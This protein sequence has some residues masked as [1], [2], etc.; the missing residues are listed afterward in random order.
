MARMARDASPPHHNPMDTFTIIKDEENGRRFLGAVREATDKNTHALGFLPYGVYDEALSA[1]RLWVVVDDDEYLG[2]LLFGGARPQLKVK[3]LYVA[4]TSRRRGIARRLIDELVALGEAEGYT[5]IR[6][7]VADDLDANLA[8]ERLG[9]KTGSVVRGGNTTG[10]QIVVR[11]RRLLPRGP[12]THFLAMLDEGC[13]TFALIARGMPLNR[14]HWYTIDL[15]VWL[16]FACR[17]EPFYESA[18]ALI[19]GASRG[20]YRL[21]FTPEAIEEARRSARGRQDDPLHAIAAAWQAVPDDGGA[22]VDVLVEKLRELIFPERSLAGRRAAN[23]TSDL[24]HLALSIRAGASGFLTREQ[25]LLRHRESLWA[26]YGLDV[27]APIDLIEG[28]EISEAARS[29]QIMDVK[30][31]AITTRW[32]DATEAV[33]RHIS[34]G[35]RLRALDREDDGWVIS[36]SAG[37]AGVVYWRRPHR[38]DVE[39]F[40]AV[41]SDLVL[42]AHLHQRIFDIL[43]GQVVAN[44][45]SASVLFRLLLHVDADS[46]ERYRADLR[47]LGF[48]DTLDSD[49]FIRFRSG[50]P[51]SVSTWATV[52]SIV[53]QEI[54]VQSHW[55]GDR[56]EGPV[57]RFTR[58][59][60]VRELSRFDFETFFGITA[61]TL[62]ARRAHFVPISPRHAS[63]L[64][65]WTPDPELFQEHDASFRIERVYFR[66]PRNFGGVRSGDLV[67]FYET[68]PIQAVVGLARCTASLVLN[69]KEAAERF[70]RLAVLDPMALGPEVHC[71]AFDNYIRLNPVAR[72]WLK[73][74]GAIPPQDM[75]SVVEVPSLT[76]AA[77]IERG[78]RTS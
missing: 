13:P 71:I 46:V 53:E 5:S 9:F 74:H 20:D 31:E 25:A 29:R 39:A 59:S 76:A 26:R 70:R 60:A 38:G 11:H 55:L 16:D 72:K 7:R 10:R 68:S 6:A 45:A 47:R 62:A 66:S 24:R 40:L 17:R 75:I 4:P 67:F 58:E 65:P 50:D 15:N 56:V 42:G 78:L 48:F 34:R 44:G 18:R 32:V 8:W 43:L 77:L 12:Q 41:E 37:V 28:A 36:T 21:R 73:S 2:H 33:K 69:A 23:D 14:D 35:A 54:C 52:Q 49:R 19:E 1:G 3:Q 63:E 57:L 22:D 64:L 51:L 30:V 61:L 27:L